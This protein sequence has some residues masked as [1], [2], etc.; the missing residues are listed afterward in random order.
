MLNIV[1]YEPLIP[2]NTG[3]VMRTC[4]GIGAQLHL[5]EPLGFSL[6]EKQLKRSAL[7][8]F[9]LLKYKVYSSFESFVKENDGYYFFLTRYGK[10]TYSDIDFKKYFDKPVYLIFGKETTGVDRKILAKHQDM[11]FRI[12]TNDKIRSLNL[13]NSVS[14]VAY[15]YLRQLIF[16][17]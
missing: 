1:L 9:P 8:Y 3:N 12:P 17:I 7:D 13:S 2:Q 6:E 4:V 14:I 16:L 5:I 10:K 15:E 11:S